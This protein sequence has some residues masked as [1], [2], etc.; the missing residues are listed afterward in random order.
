V[1]G[2]SRLLP[3]QRREGARERRQGGARPRQYHR[4]RRQAGLPGHEATQPL[5]V[6]AVSSPE[7]FSGAGATPVSDGYGPKDNAFSGR[8]RWVQIDLSADAADADH[9]SPPRSG[10][11]SPWRG[12]DGPVVEAGAGGVGFDRRGEDAARRAQ[13]TT[14][15]FF[16]A[17]AKLAGLL[18]VVTSM[19]AMGLS[20]TLPQILA[21]LRDVRQVSLALLGNFVLVPLAVFLITLVIPLA[22][23]V[24]IGLILLATAA[25]AP[26]L[27]KLVQVARGDIAFGVGLMVLLMVVT[28]ASMPLVLPLLLPGVQVDP[29]AIAQSLIVLMLLPLGVALLVRAHAPETA[30]SFEPV[31]TR[32]S[33]LAILVLTVDG[34]GL[35]VANILGMVGTGG[36]LALL[37]FIGASFAIGFVLGE[38]AP[39]ARS[40]LGLGTGRRYVSAALVVGAILLLALMPTARR[41]GGRMPAHAPRSAG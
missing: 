40:V 33:S 9:P 20:L 26:F 37:R 15:E 10:C 25:G 35:N 1:S 17:I 14:T 32:A 29:W 7:T 13:M 28:I 6:S 11:A 22:D 2:R 12:V 38:R 36:I 4:H 16:G 3:R 41:L 8:V 5:N 23:P 34:L 39:G 18:F 19:V 31:M 27:P 30:A 24:R 21:P